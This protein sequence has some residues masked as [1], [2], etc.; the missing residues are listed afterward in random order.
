MKAILKL[1]RLNNLLI[2]AFTQVL[3]AGAL[4]RIDLLN[5]N[6]WLPLGVLIIS[7]I[8]IAAGG[9]IIND[10]YDIKID[11]VNRPDRV[12]IGTII[13]RREAMAMHFVVTLIGLLLALLLSWK[14]G[15]IALFCAYF[16]WY[17][18]RYLKKKPLVG[19]ITVAL[20]TALSLMQVAVY[21]QKSYMITG[22]YAVFAFA[23]SLIRE[24]IKD[25]EDVDGDRMHGGRTVPILWGIPKTKKLLLGFIVLFITLMMT[26][27]SVA[28]NQRLNVYFML[29]SLPLM[30]V[31]AYL[32]R[33]DT[34]KH[35]HRL[36]L[37][38][39]LLMLGG[40]LSMLMIA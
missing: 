25:M 1:I 23:L 31:V 12:T 33:A 16:L 37:F 26:W 24:L 2:V 17:Y 35:Y 11:Y 32:F 20:L 15:L 7:T 10:Y 40:V 6:N 14:T 39:K 5:E 29:L 22:I 27:M 4:V 36:S 9:Y 28:D 19:N 38:C 21:Y 8:L 34:K 18:S 30:L 13:T 3:V